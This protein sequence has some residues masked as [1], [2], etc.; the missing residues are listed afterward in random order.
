ML[1]DFLLLAQA[2]TSPEEQIEALKGAR[3]GPSFFAG[4]TGLIL[5][6]ILVLV[7][8]LFFWAFFLRKRPQTQRGSLVVGRAHKENPERYGSSGRRRRR[9][10]KVEHPDNLPRNPTLSEI[11]GLPPLRSDEPEPPA[12]DDGSPP[13]PQPQR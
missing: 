9:K 6:A 7:A 1:T 11:G 2:G 5:G 10:R 13:S 12:S 3:G 4:E 8:L